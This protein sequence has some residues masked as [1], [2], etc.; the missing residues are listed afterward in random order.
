[1]SKHQDPTSLLTM[2]RQYIL[3]QIKLLQRPGGLYNLIVDNRTESVLYQ[4]LTKQQL[5]RIVA[6]I[7]KLDQKRR[8]QPVM[9]AIYFVEP[10][11]YN[12]KC[13]IADVQLQRY[14]AGHSLFLP[15]VEEDELFEFFHLGKFVRNSKVSAYFNGGSTIHFIN[16]TMIPY[17]SRIFLTDKE[18]PNLMPIYYNYNCSEYVISQVKL[19]ARSLVNLMVI[20]G[21][22]PLIRFYCPLNA[23]HQASRLP[24]LIAHEFQE[25]IDDYA[26]T[27]PEFPP[28]QGNRPRSIV[29]IADRTLDLYAPLLHEFTYQAMLM[30]IVPSLER[31]GV[32]KYKSENERG[33]VTDV[34]AVLDNEDDEDWVNL[35]H[36]HII[37]LLELIANKINEL[38]KNNPL[39]LDRLKA[40][41]ASDLALI[42][43]RMPG[44]DQERKQITLHRK[45]IDECL[46]INALRKLA[47]FAADFEQTCAAQG[48]SFE[49]VRNKHLHDDL[50]DLLARDDLHV[51]DKMRL[52]LIYGLYRGGLIEADFVKLV[53]FIGVNDRHIISL[54]SRCFTNLHKMGFTIIKQKPLDKNNK[55]GML[56]TINNEG[57]YNTSRFGSA[58]KN[59]L[60]SAIRYLLDE[61]EFPYFRDK[62]LE[63]DMPSL[64]T[65]NTNNTSLRNTRVKASWATPS[66]RT[67]N[68]FSNSLKQRVFCY[69]AGGMTY[70]EMRGVYELSSQLKKDIYLGSESILKPRDFLIGLQG[71]D[72]VKHP[73]ELN[74]GLYRQRLQAQEEPPAY[75]FDDGKPKPIVQAPAPVPAADASRFNKPLPNTAPKENVVATE[76]KKR[77]KLKSLFK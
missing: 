54:I 5:L 16:A 29:L 76:K 27:H 74:F 67:M 24:E 66:S 60:A 68:A 32:Y 56:H 7:D 20:T 38:I 25:Q 6:A 4:V 23:T 64:P 48:V 69:V 1:M 43:A 45:L 37:E 42:L 52:V 75:L 15:M 2:Q 59:V 49:G 26:R 10:T 12:L 57:T 51:N 47:E 73:H 50:I 63:E 39:M 11:L 71:M 13:I 58:V 9:E 28:D 40:N 77:S 21:E 72:D 34:E 8:Q 46:D 18:T 33:E 17:E 30:D 61:E 70:S 41:N 19:A 3:D 65:N 53:K 14:K 35:R 55:K 31:E 44:F 22:Y 62:P 36:L